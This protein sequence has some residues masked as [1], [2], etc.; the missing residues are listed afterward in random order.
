ME[1]RG[2]LLMSYEVNGMIAACQRQRGPP[3][4]LKKIVHCDIA[5]LLCA[6]RRSCP[7]GCRRV[8]IPASISIV[9]LRAT[10]C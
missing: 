9:L 6:G 7:S 5:V 4:D 2:L 1:G 8:T 3:R 10:S